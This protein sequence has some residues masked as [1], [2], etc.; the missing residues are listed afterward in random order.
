MPAPLWVPKWAL[1]KKHIYVVAIASCKWP[2]NDQY[3]DNT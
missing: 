3:D 2:I 1:K